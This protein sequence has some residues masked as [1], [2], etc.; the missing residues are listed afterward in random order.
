MLSLSFQWNQ[1]QTP[2]MEIKYLANERYA[3][4]DAFVD[5]HPDSSI[6]HTTAWKTIIEHSFAKEAFYI[7]AEDKGEICGIL[8][9]FKFDSRLSGKRLVSM[10]HVNYGGPLYKTQLAADT[11]LNEADRIRNEHGME[12]TELRMANETHFSYPVREDKVTFFMD[13]PDD[14]EALWKSFKSKLRS[15]IR[16][17]QKAGMYAKVGGL[18]L[19][20]DYYNVFCQNMRDLGTPVYSRQFFEHIFEQIPGNTRIVAVYS[21]QGSIVAAAFMIGYK[22][23]MEIPWAS[24]LRA[25]NRQSPNMLLYWEVLAESVRAG[26]KRFDFGRCTK[27]GGTYR[28]KKQWGAEEVQLYWY[29]QMQEGNPLPAVQKENPRYALA[30][31]A[32]QKLPLAVANRLGPSIVKELP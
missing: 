28:F 26:Y 30:I 32:W 1:H 16:R 23:T 27:E 6:Y 17:P 14:E 29:Y 2:N 18:E 19:L 21:S 15:Q 31:K 11:L 10:P 25:Y 5:H 7:M 13:L 4:W 9:L 20:D 3:D 12:A 8:P 24:S 22:K